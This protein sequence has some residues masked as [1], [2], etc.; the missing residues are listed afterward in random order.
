M[1]VKRS[2]DHRILGSEVVLA[3]SAM[4]VVAALGLTGWLPAV[5]RSTGDLLLRTPSLRSRPEPPIVAILIDDNAVSQRGALPWPRERLARLVAT[6]SDL[7][8]RA[9]I[10]DLILSEPAQATSDLAFADAMAEIPHVLGAALTD[11]DRWLLPLDIFGGADAAAHVYG[12]VGPDGVVRTI[13]ATKQADGLSLPALSLAAARLLRPQIPVPPGVELRPE[14]QPPPQN[15]PRFSASAVLDRELPENSIRNRIVFVGV[16]ATGAGDQFVVPTGPRHAPVPGVLAHASAAASILSGRLIRRPGTIW[17]VIAAFVLALAVQWLRSRRGTFDL[18]RFVILITGLAVIAIVALQVALVLVPLATLLAVVVVSALLREAVESRAARLESGRLLQSL[19]EHIGARS[20]NQVPQTASRRLE[21]LQRLQ[22]GVLREDATRRALLAGMAEGVALW[23]ADGEL[24]E[25]NPAAEKLWGGRPRLG[26]IEAVLDP[27]TG[28]GALKRA[29]HELS[30]HT[31]SPVGGLHANT[32]D[33]TAERELARR[34]REMQRLVSHELKT[35]LASISGFGETLERYELTGDE[36]RRVASLIRGEAGRLQEMVT[37]F[38]DLERLGA[39]HWEGEAEIVD[40]S[41]L[42]RGR[43]E[44]LTAAADARGQSFA[45]SLADGCR[46]RG[47]PALL[48]RVVDNLLGNAIKYSVDGDSIEVVVR[49]DNE[50]IVFS[51]CDH[52]PGIPADE[53]PRLSERFY[54]IAGAAESGSG[55]GLALVDEIATWHGG[56]IYIESEIGSGSTFT[57]ELPA[58]GED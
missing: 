52:G 42:V 27:A 18:G 3:F 23:G 15:I 24:L 7:D 56:C 13:A 43:L 31:S 20:G 6:V 29:G 25:V 30:L 16:S 35:P 12:E 8:A 32:R 54:R 2:F 4:A 57:V 39:G 58:V 45:P 5:E 44:I 14:F 26:E 34:R 47:V 51:V 37:V 33:V 41:E 9:V 50:R 40:F 17:V 28:E 53:I 48:D 21:A 46:V 10:F 22:E 38:L 55:L 11:G 19:L 49:A 1:R 36:Q